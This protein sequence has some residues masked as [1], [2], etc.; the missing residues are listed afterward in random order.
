M[1]NLLYTNTGIAVMRHHAT[2]VK[3]LAAADP[4]DC[5]ISSKLENYPQGFQNGAM[6]SRVLPPNISYSP[7]AVTRQG[8][9]T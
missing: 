3:R 5:A 8:C 4:A 9:S 1:R 2:V 6:L 7:A